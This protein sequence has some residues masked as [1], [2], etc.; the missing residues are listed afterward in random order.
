M[1]ITG[2]IF[3]T[4][5]ALI[6]AYLFLFILRVF[7]DYFMRNASGL[8]R[9]RL[10][11]YKI[12]N[13][14]VKLFSKTPGMLSIVSFLIPAFILIAAAYVTNSIGEITS[15]EV[16][17]KTLLEQSYRI[18]NFVTITLLVLFFA[19]LV[20]IIILYNNPVRPYTASNI[21][22]LFFKISLFSAW[23]L[24]SRLRDNYKTRLILSA[25][26]FI[27]LA[28]LFIGLGKFVGSE[29]N[30]YDINQLKQQFT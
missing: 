17:K 20:R 21:D 8:N 24:P 22:N 23:M 19:F 15:S 27:T 18:I 25:V 29:L 5:S 2:Y 4:I 3:R 11:L 6:Y 26:I 10:F 7:M 13:P 30:N 28:I 9:I 14:F 1:E 12:T 16:L